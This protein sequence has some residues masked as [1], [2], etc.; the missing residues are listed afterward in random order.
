MLSKIIVKFKD[1][2]IYMHNSEGNE[3][4]DLRLLADMIHNASTDSENED[5]PIHSIEVILA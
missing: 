2:D 1:G 3:V 5:S 4:N